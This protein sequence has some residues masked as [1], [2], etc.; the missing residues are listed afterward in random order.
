MTPLAIAR[1]AVRAWPR[2][3]WASR[4]TTNA[5]RRGYIPARLQLGDRYLLA[6]EQFVVRKPAP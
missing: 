2:T 4:A 1:D 6:R 3:P 5:L